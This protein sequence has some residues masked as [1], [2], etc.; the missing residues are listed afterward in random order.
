MSAL[1]YRLRDLL[2]SLSSK[3]K[4]ISEAETKARFKF[5][6]IVAESGK[7][8]RHKCAEL[9][10]SHQAFYKWAEILLKTKEILSLRSRSRRPKRSPRQTPKRTAKRVRNLR[11]LEPFSGPE[12]ISRDL[13]V[14]YNIECPPSTVYNVLRREGLIT[15]ETKKKLTKRHLKRYRRPFPGWLQMDFKYVPYLIEGAQHYQLSAVDH[16]SSWRL[17]RVYPHK[18]EFAVEQ[19]LAELKTLC[20]FPIIQLQTDNDTAF[21]DKF[22]SQLNRPT[23]EHLVD[24]WCQQNGVEHKLIPVGEK[25][26]NGKVENTHKFDDREFFSQVHCLTLDALKLHSLAYNE[27]WNERRATKA[28]GWQTPSEVI[29]E[30]YVR[31]YAYL[32]L[33]SEK[34]PPK[35]I[36]IIRLTPHGNLYVDLP[37]SPPKVAKKRITKKMTIIDRYLQYMDWEEKQRL[38]NLIPP[39]AMSQ[40]FSRPL[41]F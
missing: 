9:G 6:K 35:Q 21:T 19:F 26:L 38:K 1:K 13:K 5:L 14:H 33:M 39:V 7:P 41:K 23:G 2:P 20:P 11:K 8:V 36:S 4:G 31:A 22:S 16:H 28:L 10:K 15:Q 29:W 12:R 32:R 34:F 18:N 17:I 37:K 27:R 24:W 40:I 30:S 25:E 3:A